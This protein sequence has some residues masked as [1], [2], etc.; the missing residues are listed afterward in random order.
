MRSTI[1]LTIVLL[2][3]PL[4]AQEEE[5][6]D[7]FQRKRIEEFKKLKLVEALDLTEEESVRFFP[8]YNELQ[9][10]IRELQ[11]K[12]DDT[13]DDIQ[14]LIKGGEKNFVPKKYD[15]LVRRLAQ[16]ND[17]GEK[18]KANFISSLEE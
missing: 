4:F 7:P 16:I 2:A 14:N 6:I 11:M 15:E 8:R 12:K 10:K 9:N 18:V 3:F 17:E 13:V 1:F 5:N